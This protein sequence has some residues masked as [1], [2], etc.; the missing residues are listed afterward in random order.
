MLHNLYNRLPEDA[1]SEP[2]ELSEEDP[3]RV[4][5]N[6]DLSHYPSCT[7]QYE[8]DLIFIEER[9]DFEVD[10]STP[11]P[12]CDHDHLETGSVTSACVHKT[13]VLP[14][15]VRLQN[16]LSDCL[17]MASFLRNKSTFIAEKES[18]LRLSFVTPGTFRTR[19]DIYHGEL[20]EFSELLSSEFSVMHP[21]DFRLSGDSRYNEMRKPTC[22]SQ[23]GDGTHCLIADKK[24]QEHFRLTRW[25]TDFEAI[26]RYQFPVRNGYN[27]IGNDFDLM[28]QMPVTSA[29]K[30]I[31]AF[32]W[33]ADWLPMNWKYFVTRSKKEVYFPDSSLSES[34]GIDDLQEALGLSGEIEV[35]VKNMATLPSSG[36]GKSLV[37]DVFCNKRWNSQRLPVAVYNLGG[38]VYVSIADTRSSH[39]RNPTSM[40]PVTYSSERDLRAWARHTY[41]PFGNGGWV[42]PDCTVTSALSKHAHPT[43]YVVPRM[44]VTREQVDAMKHILNTQNGEFWFVLEKSLAS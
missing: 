2:P 26:N 22:I 9:E 20:P 13:S 39:K 16:S 25:S 34:I 14:D 24:Y 19:V 35:L 3:D 33:K 30:P 10:V 11:C 29:F 21:F 1:W 38:G 7:E 42:C 36:K 44:H 40:T 32:N 41:I 31:Y 12:I 6:L 18:K 17:R 43:G 27:G 8:K 37:S 15:Y 5:F 23:D 4:G 28:R